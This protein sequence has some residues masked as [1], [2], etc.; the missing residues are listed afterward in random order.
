MFQPPQT[1]TNQRRC[2]W[3][4]LRPYC[5]CFKAGKLSAAA[6]PFNRPPR[7]ERWRQRRNL[8][9]IM[10]NASAPSHPSLSLPHPSC[11]SRLLAA[12]KPDKHRPGHKYTAHE[13]VHITVNKVGPFRC[14]VEGPFGSFLHNIFTN[15]ILLLPAT[16]TRPTGTTVFPSATLR[17]RYTAR[18]PPRRISREAR[19]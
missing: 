3:Q 4:H 1:K 9:K 16:L 18:I 15:S 17:P 7:P 12:E 8:K 5:R 2:L 14:V 13:A 19:R 6:K 11:P 10:V